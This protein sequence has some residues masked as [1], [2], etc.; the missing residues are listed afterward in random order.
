MR[1]GILGAGAL[2]SFVG[3]TLA[4]GELDVTLLDVDAAH[5]GAVARDGLV[6]EVAGRARTVRPAAMH[7][8]EADR[9]FDLVF[10]LTKTMHGRAAL[11]GSG[12]AI[13]PDTLLLSI[14]NGLGNAETVLE[15]VGAERA[16]VGMTTYPAVLAAPGRVASAGRGEIRLWSA[17]GA[18]HPAAART[19]ARTAAEVAAEVAAV[20][21][22]AGLAAVADPDVT[23]AIWEKVAFNA[24]MNA[25]AALTRAPVGAIGDSV[26]GCALVAAVVDEACRVARACG[27]A[28]DQGRIG[29][30]IDMAFAE[31]RMHEPSML[32]DIRAGRPT[33]VGALNGAIAGKAEEKGLAAPVN[34]TLARL[35]AVAEGAAGQAAE[36]R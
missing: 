6:V 35:V 14:Q 9:P 13:G 8:A 33:E 36:P 20:L 28:V 17:D 19:A 1:V 34:R 2:G 16:L 3:G 7:P 21:T 31:H 25:V 12:A 15:A 22:G 30:T 23:V 24:A 29:R 18:R 11:A 4:G 26:E 5:M 10:L 27:V 32:Q